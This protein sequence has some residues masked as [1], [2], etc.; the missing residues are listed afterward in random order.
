MHTGVGPRVTPTR[1]ERAADELSGDSGLLP[2][3]RIASVGPQSTSAPLQQGEPKKGSLGPSPHAGGK[4]PPKLL[5]RETG[6]PYRLCSVRGGPALHG[7]QGQLRWA[8]FTV[9]AP[10]EPTAHTCLCFPF[11]GKLASS[12]RR[13]GLGWSLLAS[14]EEPSREHRC[15]TPVLMLRVQ[16]EWE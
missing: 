2:P 3:H 16:Q 11:L 14:C 7:G 13:R 1:V 6:R 12:P 15:G 8:T 9:C 5:L 4:N 10:R